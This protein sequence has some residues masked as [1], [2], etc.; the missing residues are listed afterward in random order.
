[1]LATA[2]MNREG[3]AAK[4]GCSAG[5][6]RGLGGGWQLCRAGGGTESCRQ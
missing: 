3:L 5:L 4:Q 2:T 6:G 1:M